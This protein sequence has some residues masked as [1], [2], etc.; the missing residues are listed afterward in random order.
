MSCQVFRLK[1]C[2]TTKFISGLLNLYKGT[3]F[4][5]NNFHVTAWQPYSTLTPK[6]F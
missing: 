5:A 3:R 6:A 1:I 2:L 4:E